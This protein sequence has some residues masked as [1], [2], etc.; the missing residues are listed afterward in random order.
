MAKK[1]SDA[2]ME[3]AFDQIEQMTDADLPRIPESVFRTRY[4][5][6]ITGKEDAPVPIADY[7]QIVGGPNGRCM[8]IDDN[9][10]ELLY[11]VPSF[12]AP[13]LTNDNRTHKQS[14]TE[15]MAHANEKGKQIPRQREAAMKNLMQLVDNRIDPQSDFMEGW[16]SI[17]TR[18]NYIGGNASTSAS[19]GQGGNN[20]A[21]FAGEYD[22][23]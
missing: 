1:I 22:E 20:D 23:A 16:N 3:Q 15:I 14:I 10:R 2:K 4:L 5:P 21:P 12:F 19:G 13:I 7:L 17:L 6:A 18:Y 8:V 11:R 9:T